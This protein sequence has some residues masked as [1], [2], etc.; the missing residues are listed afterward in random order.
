MISVDG[1][2]PEALRVLGPGRTPN[3]S[4]LKDEGASTLNARTAHEQTDTLP[5]HTGMVTGR[6]V[7]G[8]QGHG[9][10]F[11]DDNGSDVAHAAGR[12]VASIFD[13]VHDSGRTTALFTNKDKFRVLDR[14]W[15]RAHGA[16]DDTG[17][18]D[19]RDKIDRFVLDR[20]Q[21]LVDAVV[22]SLRGDLPSLTFLHIANPD[23]AGHAHGFMSSAYLKAVEVTDRQIGQVL[24]AIASGGRGVDVILTADHGG[25]GPSHR[26]V[27]MA[28]NYTIPFY[29]W[30]P[31]AA[32]GADL[33][34]LNPSRPNPGTSRPSYAGK[35]PIRNLDVAELA[36][37]LLG[38]PPVPGG[39]LAGTAP[40]RTR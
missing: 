17:A 26:D 20:P 35:Q 40:L 13:V 38:L 36:V 39:Q 3:F 25:R 14:S 32:K 15:D 10:T 8:A 2:N 23:E 16:A 19:G 4:R 34:A 30:G 11:N 33:Y 21:V 9:V 24:N 37:K 5:N 1:L 7:S 18:D 27:T 12:Y 31:G 29:V 28:D 6:P 22:A